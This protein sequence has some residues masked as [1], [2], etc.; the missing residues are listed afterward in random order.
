M[1]KDKPKRKASEETQQRQ[2]A[3]QRKRKKV[4]E[5]FQEPNIPNH[6][7]ERDPEKN[8]V[9]AMNSLG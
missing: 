3:I 8:V 6:T 5:T 1:G 7:N 2:G 4:G 9:A